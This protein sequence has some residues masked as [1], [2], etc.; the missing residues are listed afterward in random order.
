M[1]WFSFFSYFFCLFTFWF[2]DW[3]VCGFFLFRCRTISRDFVCYTLGIELGFFFFD[4]RFRK[5]KYMNMSAQTCRKKIKTLPLHRLCSIERKCW[6]AS[7]VYYVT[8]NLYKKHKANH[9]CST[10]Q[11]PF[12]SWWRCVKSRRH[13]FAPF[14]CKLAS[15]FSVHVCIATL[16]LRLLSFSTMFSCTVDTFIN[17][18]FHFFTFFF[19]LSSWLSLNNTLA[20]RSLQT[21]ETFHTRK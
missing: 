9:N 16:L 15:L 8:I 14:A 7:T 4:Q 19:F 3:T 17:V 10:M 18:Y 20:R 2:V 13:A 11:Q 12:N 6:R 21:V 5:R 1:I